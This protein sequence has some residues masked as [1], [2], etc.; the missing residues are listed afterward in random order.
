MYAIEEQS[1]RERDEWGEKIRELMEEIQLIIRG[2]RGDDERQRAEKRSLSFL[3]EE[4]EGGINDLPGEVVTAM[5]LN[6]IAS[7]NYENGTG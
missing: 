5:V 1:D 6:E 3:D 2:D 7:L 4:I